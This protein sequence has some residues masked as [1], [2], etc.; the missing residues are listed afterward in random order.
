MERSSRRAAALVQQL[1][2][3][4]QQ[5]SV[6]L[7]HVNAGSTV[8][9]VVELIARGLPPSVSIE[10]SIERDDLWFRGDPRQLEQV[11]SNLCSNAHDALEGGPEAGQIRVSVSSRT[12]SPEEA[13]RTA[14]GSR[15]G[16]WVEI[17]VADNGEGIDPAT[18]E[19]LFDP[20]FTTKAIG[21]GSGLGL[22]VVLGIVRQHGGW[23][24]VSDA[25]GGGGEFRG[26]LRQVSAPATLD[27]AKPA[28]PAEQPAAPRVLIIDDE[29]VVR[30]LASIVLEREGYAIEQAP[31]GNA[32]LQA[33]RDAERDFDLVLLDLSMPGLDG[34]ETLDAIRAEGF[35]VPVVL[36]SGFNL[37]EEERMELGGAQGFLPKPFY[38]RQLIDAVESI[39]PEA[40]AS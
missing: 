17:L 29:S 40:G 27:T 7:T 28:Q 5:S 21:R 4:G 10:C 16:D 31:D 39:L 1:L 15:P 36:I 19:R 22:A 32:G 37:S 2:A 11:V 34:W 6:F 35:E 25:P 23:I 38:G 3:F 9:E 13:D 24:A 26:F 12:V 14:D 33:L 30:R 20:F 18:R 8:R